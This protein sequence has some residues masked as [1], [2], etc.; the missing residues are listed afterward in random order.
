M[1]KWKKGNL[2]ASINEL[3]Y[4]LSNSNSKTIL[5]KCH[6]SL[7]EIST[8]LL[9]PDSSLFHLKNAAKTT[10]NRD[11]KGIIYGRLAELAFNLGQYE[12]AMNGYSNVVAH[13][14]S[15]EKIENA[16]LQML[17]ILRIQKNYKLASR[18]IKAL[19]AD[20]KFK[21]ISGI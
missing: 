13:S 1:C 19:L 16:H 11:E 3:N 10:Q 6:L 4:L 14:L 2:Q 7:A 8:E 20:D 21:R 17:K 18:K 12:I 5:S 15:K 9:N